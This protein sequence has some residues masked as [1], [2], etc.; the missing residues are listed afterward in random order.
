MCK[1]YGT[2]VELPEVIES[3]EQKST[4]NTIYYP[5]FLHPTPANNA[6]S[7]KWLAESVYGSISA[8]LVGGGGFMSSPNIFCTRLSEKIKF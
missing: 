5:P 7:R 4:I 2:N 1:I 8:L 3:M 6:E